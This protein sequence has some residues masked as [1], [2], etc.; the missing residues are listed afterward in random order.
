MT[1]WRATTFL[2]VSLFAAI[3]A[4]PSKAVETH[5]AAIPTDTSV[6]LRGKLTTL[7]HDL[8][9]LKELN[10]QAIDASRESIQ[11][12][13]TRVQAQIEGLN[14]RVSDIHNRVSDLSLPLGAIPIVLTILGL[15]IGAA[16]YWTAGRR[17]REAAELPRTGKH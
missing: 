10:R 2:L 11:K 15:G 3:P 16:A 12:D 6:E 7:E 4:A 1:G 8:Q 9:S 5:D 17:A 14:T 13:I